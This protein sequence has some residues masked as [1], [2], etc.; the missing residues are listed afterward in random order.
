L[1]SSSDSST[2]DASGRFAASFL[3]RRSVAPFTSRSF[4]GAF[5][6]AGSPVSRTWIRSFRTK[7]ALTENRRPTRSDELSSDSASKILLRKSNEIAAMKTAYHVSRIM[8]RG[9]RPYFLTRLRT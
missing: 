3:N 6:A 9:C 5:P 1:A 2:S 4:P 7:L 8:E